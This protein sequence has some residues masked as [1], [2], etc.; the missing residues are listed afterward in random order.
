M[1]LE[2][3]CKAVQYHLDQATTNPVS[4][5]MRR[6]TTQT[7]AIVWE[8]SDAWAA[9]ISQTMAGDRPEPVAGHR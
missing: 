4:V 3:V 7:P 1:S 6:P 2:T 8:I 9:L 5:G